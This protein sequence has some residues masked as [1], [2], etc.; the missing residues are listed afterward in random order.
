MWLKPEEVLLKNALKLWLMERSNDYFVLQR[1]RGYG[2]DGGGG[3][4]GKLW[5]PS[6]ASELWSLILRRW[7]GGQLLVATHLRILNPGRRTGVLPPPPPLRCSPRVPEN[8]SLDQQ[9]LFRWDSVKEDGFFLRQS[10]F[11]V[12]S[13]GG[14]GWWVLDLHGSRLGWWPGPIRSCGLNYFHKIP[15]DNHYPEECKC[16]CG[17]VGRGREDGEKGRSPITSRRIGFKWESKKWGEG[18]GEVYQIADLFQFSIFYFVY[19][20]S[21][22][23]LPSLSNLRSL[24]LSW[25]LGAALFFQ[26]HDCKQTN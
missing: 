22:L 9:L 6:P 15:I 7:W 18:E 11:P 3:L 19:M 4:T 24:L 1:R 16:V 14:G 21:I 26:S 20:V 25:V 2:E 13:L 10:T 17:G 23:G 5:P 8:V 12:A